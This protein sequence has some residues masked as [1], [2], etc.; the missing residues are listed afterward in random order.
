MKKEDELR[1]DILIISGTHGNETN[2]IQDV[3]DFSLRRKDDPNLDFFA[4]MEHS[5][6]K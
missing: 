3:Y 5:C 1:P 6:I 2:A 4:C